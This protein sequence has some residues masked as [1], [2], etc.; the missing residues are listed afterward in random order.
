[1]LKPDR[2]ALDYTRLV[3]QARQLP[4]HGRPLKLALLGDVSTQHLAP[5]LRALFSTNGFDA[6]IL[7]AGY[8]TVAQ[9]TLDPASALHSFRP[10][11]IVVLQAGQRLAG[12]YAEASGDRTAFP[13]THADAI[14]AT[15]QALRR[16]GTALIIQGNFVLPAER[17]FGHYGL[18]VE[19]TL[20]HAVMELN[21]ELA[22][23]ARRLPGVSILDLD[24]LAGWIGRRHFL[25]EK[26]WVLAK[27]LCAVELLPEV[28]QGIV[29][30]ALAAQGQAVKAVVLDLD[31]TLWGGVVGDDGLEGIG[32][33]ELDDGGVFRSFQLFLRELSRRGVI[34]AVCSKNDEVLARRVF[35]EHPGMVL[36]EADIAVFVANWDDKATNLRRIRDRLNLGFEAMVFL[37]DH[38][39]ERNLARTLPGL[40]V[41]ELPDDPARYVRTL[42]ELNLFETASHSALDSH[43]VGLQR[44]AEARQEDRAGFASLDDYLRS[45]ATTAVVARFTAATLPRIVQLIQRSNQFNL[46]TRRYTEAECALL[47]ERKDAGAPF[48]VSLADRHGEIGLVCVVVLRPAGAELEIES[49]LMSCRVLQRGVEQLAMNHIFARARA[50]GHGRVVGHYLPTPKNGLV[51]DF[52]ARFGF[53]L[54]RRTAESETWSLGVEA[55]EPRA[56]FIRELPAADAPPTLAA[57]P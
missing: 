53:A 47:A 22:L 17:P 15:W 51:R 25:D 37:D 26:W 9:E 18:K 41:P 21:R 33:G 7:E 28:A 1:M 8:D 40:I 34:L 13:R 16:R 39:F 44:A 49:L 43:R 54:D 2:S 6:E 35:R 32:L 42:S 4:V 11:V 12:A 31:G 20:Q 19:D 3:K 38:P 46:T 29:D 10:D 50:A 23:R 36:R 30:I 48:T 52:Y 56:V 27:S 14:E 24:F 45:L 5:V 55:Y 57:P